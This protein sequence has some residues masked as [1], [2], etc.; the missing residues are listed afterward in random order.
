MGARTVLGLL[1]LASCSTRGSVEL[2]IQPN[3]SDVDR[4][5]LYIGVGDEMNGG[6]TPGGAN[7]PIGPLSRWD[8]DEHN[9]LSQV[10]SVG[11]KE[12]TFGL[13]GPSD[14]LPIVI[15]VGFDSMDRPISAAVLP[16]ELRPLEVPTHSISRY[17]LALESITSVDRSSPLDVRVWKA[18]DAGASGDKHECVIASDARTSE[19]AAILTAN[20]PDCDA[21]PDGDSKECVKSW[22]MASASPRIENINCLL[23]ITAM[24]NGSVVASAVLGGDTC[25]DGMGTVHGCAP[26]NYCVP[27][28]LL[29]GCS[30]AGYTCAQD[31]SARSNV[32]TITHMECNVAHT[33]GGMLCEDSL[34]GFNN[35]GP[36]V[37]NHACRPDSIRITR[38]GQPW[39]TQVTVAASAGQ[40]Q[41]TTTLA[42]TDSPCGFTLTPKG[43]GPT[44]NSTQVV[45][46]GALVAGELDNGRGV[47]IPYVFSSEPSHVG[48]GSPTPCVPVFSST[49][50]DGLSGCIE[51][52]ALMP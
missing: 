19:H 52:P 25:V 41:I 44:T 39:G 12:I 2:V 9:E 28:S 29:E 7:G 50:S 23:P 45:T 17:T 31:I 47:A 16:K 5:A 48:C 26:S 38:P 3:S 13:E 22:F 21:W 11:G 30:T 4:V 6:I 40:A 42:P 15:A 35:P 34:L 8:R 10:D 51:S 49:T 37:Q 14:P 36:I 27:R 32:P 33:D 20:D 18:S 46:W 24:P 43:P 1:V